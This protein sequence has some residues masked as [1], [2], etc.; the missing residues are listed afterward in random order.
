M[1]EIMHD[2]H[3]KHVNEGKTHYVGDACQ[4][5]HA[6]EKTSAWAEEETKCS[7]PD[8]QPPK[9]PEWVSAYTVGS[10][11]YHEGWESFIRHVG[12]E[13]GH[14]LVLIEP[15]RKMNRAAR[16]REGRNA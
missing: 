10:S 6:P 15:V 14:W 7:P 5:P 9:P 3:E 11:I 12:H 13:D 16:R 1:S 2:M 8:L 4:P